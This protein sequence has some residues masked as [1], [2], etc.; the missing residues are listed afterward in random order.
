MAKAADTALV[1]KII[2]LHGPVI[3]LRKNPEVIIDILRRFD[4]PPDGGT[5]CGGVPPTPTPPSPS[6]A[7]TMVTNDDLMKAILK[8]SRDVSTLKSAMQV[9]PKAKG[10]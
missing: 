3:D 8:L 10:R 9:A 6:L 1:N 7:A 4:E 2:K 5:P